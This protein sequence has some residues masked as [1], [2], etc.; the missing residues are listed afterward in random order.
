METIT[1]LKCR[2]EQTNVGQRALRS[3]RLGDKQGTKEDQGQDEGTS[4]IASSR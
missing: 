2:E 4:Y 1:K 3:A